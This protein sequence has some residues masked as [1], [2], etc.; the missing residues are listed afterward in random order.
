M[1]PEQKAYYDGQL[2]RIRC[3]GSAHDACMLDHVFGM[4]SSNLGTIDPPV[5]VFGQDDDPYYT[6]YLQ[7]WDEV[8][9]LVKNL[10]EEATKAWGQ[11]PLKVIYD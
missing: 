10:R 1:T 11:E 3:G 8:N 7:D 5:V 4:G 2:K 9:A 6:Q